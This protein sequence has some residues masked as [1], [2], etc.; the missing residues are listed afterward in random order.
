[1]SWELVY[2]EIP[3]GLMVC[4]HCDN[5]ICVRPDHLWLGTAADNSRDMWNKGRNVF[6]K[7][8]IPAQKLS[9]DQVTAIRKAYAESSVTAKAL[10]ENYGVSQGQIR[11]IVN[12]VR[13]GQNTFQNKGIPKPG[14]KLNE[15]Q[16]KMIRKAYA[17][18]SMTKKALSKKYG[19]SRSQISRIVNGISWAHLD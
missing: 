5:P 15:Y 1:V 11:K 14:E 8:G 3:E 4:H 18:D 2:G 7:K 9:R 17:K 16:V 13:W 12:G 19:V 6:Q 10:A